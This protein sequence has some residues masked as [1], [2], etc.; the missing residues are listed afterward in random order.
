[1]FRNFF[2]EARE[3]GYD[4]P[5]GEDLWKLSLIIALNK[6]RARG[7]FHRAANGDVR[8]TRRIDG[9]DPYTLAKENTHGQSGVTFMKMAAEEGAGP[10]AAFACADRGTAHARLPGSRNR[11][12]DREELKDGRTHAPALPSTAHRLPHRRP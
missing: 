8:R 10:I 11:R 6:F 2:H 1:M 3:G 5:P 12:I 4:V 7:T 9:L